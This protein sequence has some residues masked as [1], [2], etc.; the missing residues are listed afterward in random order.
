M[1][2]YIRSVN[3]SVVFRESITSNLDKIIGNVKIASNLEKGIY[4]YTITVCDK[5]NLVKK[6]NNHRC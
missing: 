1:S 5:K 4:N 3:D 2:Y 6:W